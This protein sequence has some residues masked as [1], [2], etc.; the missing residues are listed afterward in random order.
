MFAMFAHYAVESFK[1]LLSSHDSLSQAILFNTI[2]RFLIFVAIAT[3]A[4]NSK[5]VPIL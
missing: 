2:Y 3:G 4:F 1:H 5:V